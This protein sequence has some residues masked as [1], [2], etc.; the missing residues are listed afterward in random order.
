M[1]RIVADEHAIPRQH[2]DRNGGEV[3]LLVG[4]D[5]G[6]DHRV[7]PCLTTRPI[8]VVDDLHQPD[9]APVVVVVAD[10]GGL[11]PLASDAV[12]RSHLALRDGR[13][14]GELARAVRAEQHE[15]GLGA[16]GRDLAFEGDID[17]DLVERGGDAVC[18]Q[19]AAE[20]VVADADVGMIPGAAP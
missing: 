6:G 18:G 4:G 5:V 16:P 8:P 19:V 3:V 9:V 7:R 15:A 11:V 1:R 14:P 13:E 20:A 2:E 17:R 12:P 10:A